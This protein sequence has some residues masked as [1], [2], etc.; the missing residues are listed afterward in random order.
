MSIN[1][2]TGLPMSINNFVTPNYRTILG[3]TRCDYRT[4]LGNYLVSGMLC[5]KQSTFNGDIEACGI[6]LL[7]VLATKTMRSWNNFIARESQLKHIVAYDI[8]LINTNV[9]TVHSFDKITW[10]NITKSKSC[11]F[12]LGDNRVELLNV[13]CEGRTT[14]LMDRV[15]A[16]ESL[17]CEVFAQT[18][19]ELINTTAKE[20]MVKNGDLSITHTK[21]FIASNSLSFK[22]L[23][24]YAN[25]T[26]MKNI[27]VNNFISEKGKIEMQN[28]ILNEVYSEGS[29]DLMNTCINVCRVIN[30][31]L[32]ILHIRSITS[33]LGNIASEA[34]EIT[35]LNPFLFTIY[36][37]CCQVDKG[38]LSI[39]A[40]SR[41]IYQSLQAYKDIIIKNIDV[42]EITSSKC[43]TLN[44]QGC[45]L[46]QVEAYQHMVFD[47]TNV[48]SA[49]LEVPTGEISTI[50]LKGGSV[51]K[52]GLIVKKAK[53]QSSATENKFAL[54]IKGRSFIQG[55]IVFSGCWEVC[56]KNMYDQYGEIIEDEVAFIGKIKTV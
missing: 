31:N 50:T 20:V 15:I 7:Y 33:M 38:E 28:C 22:E 16:T 51:V 55:L 11:Q 19:V 6:Q 14:S 21:D 37:G 13:S 54:V 27:T 25:N 36:P 10:T 2:I 29:V 53:V 5:A 30:G 43:G 46:S 17:L 8:C 3:N 49:Q 56:E 1:S 9:G 42:R 4:I 45:N 44:A 39:D 32:T 47:N 40:L 24:V 52:K 26:F 48:D 41:I 23:S 12:I 18:Q 35:T 34:N